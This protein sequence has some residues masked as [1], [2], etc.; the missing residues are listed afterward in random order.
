MMLLVGFEIFVGGVVGT[1]KK[2][3]CNY[4]ILDQRVNWD[5]LSWEQ[6]IPFRW[7]KCNQPGNL[8]SSVGIQWPEE[9]LSAR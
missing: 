2:N 9:R 6:M 3:D 7:S 1:G 4:A 5:C 8:S